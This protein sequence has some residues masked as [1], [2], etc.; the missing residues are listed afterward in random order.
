MSNFF[1]VGFRGNEGEQC[2]FLYDFEGIYLSTNSPG[3]QPSYPHSPRSQG[4]GLDIRL[5]PD[6][7]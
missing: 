2:S 3:T 6:S 5:K 1:W 4:K 7:S